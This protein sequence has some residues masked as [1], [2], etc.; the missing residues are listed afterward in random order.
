MIHERKFNLKVSQLTDVWLAQQDKS[1]W[2]D[3]IIVIVLKFCVTRM[4]TVQ[5]NYVGPY[6]I[7]SD[8][9]PIA[10]EHF[11]IKKGMKF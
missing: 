10:Q 6:D 3:C 8:Q 4:S 5:K 11:Q 7:R 9:R 1:E 2:I